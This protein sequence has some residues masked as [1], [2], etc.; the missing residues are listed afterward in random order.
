[1]PVLADV[2]S[3][4]YPQSIIDAFLGPAMKRARCDVVTLYLVLGN[5]TL[6][7]ARLRKRSR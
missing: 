7:L 6:G 5:V 2:I 4:S 3:S 1:M